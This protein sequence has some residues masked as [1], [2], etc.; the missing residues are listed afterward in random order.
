MRVAFRCDASLQIGSGHVMR[1]LTLA[2][3]LRL[4]GHEC[5]FI[6]RD[7]PGQMVRQITTAGFAVTVLPAPSDEFAPTTKAPFHAEWAEVP[8]QTDAAQT[9]GALAAG[10]DWLVLDHYAFDA[11][12]QKAV[13]PAAAQIMVI[14]DLA[15]R[16][17]AADMLLDQNLGRHPADYAPLLPD[18]AERL[19]GPRFALLRPEFERARPQS[20]ARRKACGFVLEHLL[21][22]MGGMDLPDI[23]GR[24]L[25]ALATGALPSIR[26]ISVV[27]GPS[28]PALDTVRK[29]A[30]TMPVP[31]RVLVGVADMAALMAEADLAIGAAGGTAWE[32]CVLGLPSLIVVMAHNQQQGAAALANSGTALILGA[33]EDPDLGLALIHAISGLSRDPDALATL[34]AR[35]AGVADGLGVVRMARAMETPIQLRPARLDDAQTVWQW[36]QGLPSTAFGAGGQTPLP[37]HLQWFQAALASPARTLL[38]ATHGDTP[39]GHLRLDRDGKNG[40]TVSLLLAPEARGKGFGPR[41]LDRLSD[42]ARFEG[43]HHLTAQVH[44]TNAPSRAAFLAAGYAEIG[45]SG[46]YHH[47][48]LSLQGLQ[49][50]NP[51]VI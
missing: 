19:I 40:A 6:C 16:S 27:M 5:R 36:R 43:L 14:D 37:E 42:L 48:S 18:A 13:R 11:Q 30:G 21:I 28:A 31:T 10:C 15:D 1:C 2:E 45:Q 25:A 46:G 35:A 34:S 3:A 12:W 32:R 7:L 44:T 24:A 22:F 39:L 9:C 29:M 20:L 51:R 41:L 17:H 23:T 47:L 33:V 4:R 8:W 38:L 49:T 50:P 26:Q